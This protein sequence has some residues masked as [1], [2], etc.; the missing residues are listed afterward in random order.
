MSSHLNP[1]Q[2][3]TR[4]NF[5]FSL[6]LLLIISSLWFLFSFKCPYVAYTP[7]SFGLHPFSSFQWNLRF[8]RVFHFFCQ[9]LQYRMVMTTYALSRYQ[10]ERKKLVHPLANPNPIYMHLLFLKVQD[11]KK[12]NAHR[13]ARDRAKEYFY[14][15]PCLYW[16]ITDM[17]HSVSLRY[18]A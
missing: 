4:F 12:Y 18:K 17:Q 6:T 14:F 3:P 1:T 7:S 13:K 5:T 16:D 10:C 9:R 2:L 8:F 11:W 15:I